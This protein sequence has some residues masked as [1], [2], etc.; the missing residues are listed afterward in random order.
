MSIPAGTP[1]AAL[2]TPA[3]L[4]DLDTL[5]ANLGFLQRECQQRSIALR[6]HFKSLKCGGLA[7]Y[8]TGRGVTGF[9]AA[10]LNEVE[11]LQSAGVRDILLANEIVTPNKI[12]RLASLARSGDLSVCVDDAT[13][14]RNIGAAVTQA[15]ATLGVLIEVDVGMRRCGVAPGPAAVDLAR[16]IQTTPGLR[17]LGLQGYEGHLQQIAN[18]DERKTRCLAAVGPL[19]ETR[20]LL[21]A[22]GIPVPVVTGGGTG[23]W[24][25]YAGIAGVTEIQPGSFLL[26]DCFY[27][28]LR[29][30]FACSLSILTTVVSRRENWYVLDA[31][32]KAISQD[33][34]LPEIKDRATERVAKLAEEHTRV[35]VDGPLPEIGSQREVL[36]AHCCATM[37]LH[38]TAVAVRSGKVEAVWPIESS[39]RYD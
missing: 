11:T 12:A 1:V 25:F 39:G 20:H 35:E 36:P 2:D 13:N 8:L 22:A 3:L 23:T 33:F 18:A 24:E 9:L 21:E 19:I 16:V 17:F 4:L 38:R 37:N 26:M 7:R 14:V 30:E 32:S 5:D 31:G 10:K 28:R 6:I 29:P 34:G 15:G 27:H